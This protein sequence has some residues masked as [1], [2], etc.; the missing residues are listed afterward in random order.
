MRRALAVLALL[1]LVSCGKTPVER[2]AELFRPAAEKLGEAQAADLKA[3]YEKAYQQYLQETGSK[4]EA[5]LGRR[6]GRQ[7][8]EHYAVA[9]A[10]DK[11]QEAAFKAAR[12]DDVENRKKMNQMITK[13]VDGRGS[14]S[15]IG[16][17]IILKTQAGVEW[18]TGLQLELA[19]RI[20]KAELDPR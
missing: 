5:E 7:H 4:D 11:A 3:R 18:N 15:M 16:R 12:F 14:A 9:L 19:L 2:G 13:Y 6:L 8:L 10:V 20:L 17:L 1:S